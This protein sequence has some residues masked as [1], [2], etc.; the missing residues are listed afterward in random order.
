MLSGVVYV[1]REPKLDVIILFVLNIE[2]A[3]VSIHGSIGSF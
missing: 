2:N 1:A 3:Q